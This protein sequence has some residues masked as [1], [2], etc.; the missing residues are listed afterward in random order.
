VGSVSGMMGLEGMGGLVVQNAVREGAEQV[1]GY[2]TIKYSVDTSRGD[3]ASNAI[4]LGQGGFIKGNAWVTSDG[5]PVKMTLDEE[6]HHSDGSMTKYHIEE[7][8]T[9][10]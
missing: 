10:K 2:D 1:N 8:I 7:A 5:C 4:M 9:K 6:I 3:A